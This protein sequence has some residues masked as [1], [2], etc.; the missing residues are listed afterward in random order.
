MWNDITPVVPPEPEIPIEYSDDNFPMI[1]S[2]IFGAFG[3]L[4]ILI[5]CCLDRSNSL[6]LFDTEEDPKK[7]IF[8]DLRDAPTREANYPMTDPA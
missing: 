5:G 4:F 2:I 1:A 8:F 7:R 6:L 3:F